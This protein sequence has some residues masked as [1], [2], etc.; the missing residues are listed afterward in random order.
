MLASLKLL[1]LGMTLFSKD[2]VLLLG[3]KQE[4]E[5]QMACVYVLS[6][7]TAHTNQHCPHLA[8]GLS[9]VECYYCAGVGLV[10]QG[11]IKMMPLSMA[12]P[13]AL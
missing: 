1:V 13:F 9:M 3:L 10:P 12:A 2:V 4:K 7:H 11:S 6:L 5:E 8:S